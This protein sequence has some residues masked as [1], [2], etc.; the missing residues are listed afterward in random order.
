MIE[1]V[2]TALRSH[3]QVATVQ[4]YGCGALAK[5]CYGAGAKASERKQPAVMAV[6][7]KAVVAVLRS[8][9]QVVGVQSVGCAALLYMCDGTD[10]K[11]SERKQL[12]VA[13]GAIDTV[14][15]GSTNNFFPIFIFYA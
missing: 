8:H 3:L 7:I 2:V 4:K 11:A 12:A 15:L 14:C 6:T 1:A 9:L 5:I 13:A 10:A